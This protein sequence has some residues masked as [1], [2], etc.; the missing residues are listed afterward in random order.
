M[1]KI[2]KKRIQ[3][4]DKEV[5]DVKLNVDNISRQLEDTSNKSR[6]NI[7][8]GKDPSIEEL[9][10]NISVLEKRID[11]KRDEALEKEIILEE[12]SALNIKT[13]NQIDA[14]DGP[15]K[16]KA[17]ELRDIQF[18]LKDITRGVMTS[19]SELSIYQVSV[20]SYLSFHISFLHF[21]NIIF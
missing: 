17:S 13:K 4:L 5:Q 6:I 3:E 21:N 11:Q 8:G 7:L 16:T 19:I 14:K 15:S 10:E 20:I 18:K 1:T 12:L 2:Y 9:N